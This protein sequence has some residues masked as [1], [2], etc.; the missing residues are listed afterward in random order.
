M[1]R[2]W[3]EAMAE[4]KIRSSNI[5]LLRIVAMLMI[6]VY[7]IMHHCVI[8]Y[9]PQ[10]GEYFNQPILY[11]SLVIPQIFASFGPIGNDVFIL[12]TG[13]FMANRGEKGSTRL[14]KVASKLLTQLGFATMILIAAS[15]LAV[16]AV[17]SVRI[18]AVGFHLF[19]TYAWF[20]GYYFLIFLCGALF[21]N[22]FILSLDRKGYLA[23]VLSLFALISFEWTCSLIDGL[24]N[25]LLNFVT[26]LFLYAVGGYIR[27]YEPFERFRGVFFVLILAVC[28]AV[29]AV[30][31]FNFTA[32]TIAAARESGLEQVL[33]PHNLMRFDNNSI[34]TLIVAISML[35]L[36]KR[37]RMPNSKDINFLGS[38]TFMVYLIHENAFINSLWRKDN[39]LE[40]LSR[41]PVE[42]VARC[43]MWMLICFA[44]GV[45]AYALYLAFMRACKMLAKLF[46]KP[47]KTT[48]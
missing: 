44:C 25:G 38:A 42:F 30:S 7:H 31:Q 12:I 41:S 15:A 5:E 19:N 36:F 14:T 47:E 45:A 39:W 8:T 29:T 21:F 28:V 4:K 37:I 34:I 1:R 46:L 35:E 27:R 11:K 43:A 23:L 40:I 6:I 24:T 9:L 3:G 17:R 22:R 10:S 18:E 33:M 13:Y 26:G 2:E 48:V 32:S 16:Y 20:V